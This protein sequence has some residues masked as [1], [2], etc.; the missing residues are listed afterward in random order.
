MLLVC[1]IACSGDKTKSN[2]QVQK[3]HK[4]PLQAKLA[5]IKAAADAG[6][7]HASDPGAP[8][9]PGLSFDTVSHADQAN[10]LAV[11]AE[12]AENPTADPEP[13]L[14]FQDVTNDAH[15]FVKAFVGVNVEP[16]NGIVEWAGHDV[17]FKRFEHLKYVLVIY[18]TKTQLPHK[19]GSEK[20]TGGAVT[21]DAVLVE[22]STNKILG[23][24]SVSAASSDKVLSENVDGHLGEDKHYQESLDKDL[25][26]QWGKALT[27]GITKRWPGTQ[28]PW[29]VGNSP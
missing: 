19:D 29:S 11:L 15:R 20:F 27:D 25:A 22:L 21:S 28:V 10:A 7:G 6:A 1:V 14:R 13:E 2:A 26:L 23:G 9:V 12:E 17:D 18:P 8:S 5:E 24:F 3:E 4:A 16:F